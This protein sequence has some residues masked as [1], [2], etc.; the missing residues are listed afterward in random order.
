M[1]RFEDA[2]GFRQLAGAESSQ[3]AIDAWGNVGADLVGYGVWRHNRSGWKQLI[4][5]DASSIGA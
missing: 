1:W 4:G 3:V 5:T 2:V